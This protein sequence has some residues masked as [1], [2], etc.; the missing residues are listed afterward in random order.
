[1]CSNLPGFIGPSF[2]SKRGILCRKHLSRTC[3]TSETPS[4]IS[5][6]FL[7]SNNDTL[8]CSFILSSWENRIPLNK[9]FILGGRLFNPPRGKHVLKGA[10][11]HCCEVNTLR[12]LAC[13]F[14]TLF[15]VSAREFFVEN[16]LPGLNRMT[17]FGRA[18]LSK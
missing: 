8:M 4:K 13:N 9:L 12:K 7:S 14:S 3:K 18:G 2:P 15:K 10:D 16:C 5:F 6:V 1:M 11:S 17:D